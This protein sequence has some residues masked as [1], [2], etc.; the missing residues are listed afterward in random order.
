M[1]KLLFQTRLGD[2]FEAIAKPIAKLL[3][4]P[5]LDEKGKLR[6]ESGCAKRK[7]MLNKVMFPT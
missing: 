7:E 6:P 5:C 1:K 4:L 2:K 3:K